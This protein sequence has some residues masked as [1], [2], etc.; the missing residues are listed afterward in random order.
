MKNLFLGTKIVLILLWTEKKNLFQLFDFGGG[1]VRRVFLHCSVLFYSKGN[2]MSLRILTLVAPPPPPSYSYHNV[3][4]VSFSSYRME[5]DG[6][7]NA[8]Q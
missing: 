2:K 4:F 8:A 6:G 5:R 3:S 1:W 7:E